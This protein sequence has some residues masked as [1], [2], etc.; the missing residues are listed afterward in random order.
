M[1]P[2]KGTY[3]VYYENYIP[4]VMQEN[5]TVALH[6]NW[7]ELKKVFSF[8]SKNKEDYAYAD[9]K[10]T[11]KQMLLHL[12]D[13]ERIF[14]YRALRFARKDPEQ[15]LSFEENDYAA[16]ADVSNRTLADIME[17]METVRMASISLF[18]SFSNDTLLLSGDTAAGSAT[19][20]SIGFTI[21]GHALHHI[22]VLKE[23]YA[24]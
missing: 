21:C 12:V 5:I 20:V 7:D 16:A 19:V 2:E 6:Q 4:L 18:K 17:E 24:I 23:R 1:R 10:W 9:G 8:V 15:P 22:N 11:V 13:T 14:A 3:P